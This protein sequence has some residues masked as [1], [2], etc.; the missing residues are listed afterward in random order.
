MAERKAPTLAQALESLADA[1]RQLI[2]V[3]RGWHDETVA[4]RADIRALVSSIRALTSAIELLI[5]AQD[6]PGLRE[7]D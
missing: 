3:I 6:L 2:T 7:K 4:E 1:Q 5:G